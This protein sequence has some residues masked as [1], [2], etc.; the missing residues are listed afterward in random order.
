MEHFSDRMKFVLSKPLG[1]LRTT[2]S[3]EVSGPDHGNANEKVFYKRPMRK[4][5]TEF[6]LI[7]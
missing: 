2:D 5:F 1:D 3:A 6:L 4:Y 7:S